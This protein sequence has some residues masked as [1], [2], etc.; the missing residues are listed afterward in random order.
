MNNLVKGVLTVDGD[1]IRVSM[2]FEKVDRK[3]RTVSGWATLDN[4]DTQGDIVLAEASAKAFNRARG[5]LREMHDKVAVG[6][7]VDFHE[8]EFL[9]PE[10]GKLYR[11]IYVTARVSEG[12]PNTWLKVLDGTLQGF[13]IGGE[14]KEAS[15]EFVKDAGNGGMTVRFIKDY[16]LTELSLVD[17]PANQLANVESF[18]KVFSIEKDAD[19]SVK[20]VSGMLAETKMSSV[21][22]CPND[23]H[24]VVKS[25]ESA[26]CS[27]CE[28]SM[29]NIGWFEEGPDR[30]VKVNEIVTKF[31]SPEVVTPDGDEGGV[32]LSKKDTEVK[33]EE[34]VVE[35]P[36]EE[37]ATTE[38][39]GTEEPV[40]VDETEGTE[41]EPAETPDEVQDEETEIEK[42]IDEL[43]DVVHNSLERNRNEITE[44]IAA[45]EKRVDEVATELTE[46]TSELASKYEEFGPK[47]EAA[48]SRVASLEKS[49]NEINSSGAFRKSADY[50]EEPAVTN[51]QGNDWNGAFSGRRSRFSIDNL[52]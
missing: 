8:D 52:S 26:E 28:S 3:K 31:R 15:N 38:E 4:L 44:K 46:K 41:E 2:P 9:N 11:G 30:E 7:I 20:S 51:E 27:K 33:T 21:F 14:I 6:R 34:P 12:A 48:K 17:N 19:G 35:N 1:S 50:E 24:I 36:E 47:L 43:K 5:N 39:E 42:K 32:D 25:A 10:D 29:E 23:D 22:I 18:Q 40:E 45:L 49:L 16:D 13:S 37:E